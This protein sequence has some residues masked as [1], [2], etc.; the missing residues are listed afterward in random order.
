[1][2]NHI[3]IELKADADASYISAVLKSLGLWTRSLK[4]SQNQIKAIEVLPPSIQ[5][6]STLIERIEG[7]ASVL[8][9][10]SPHP[11]VDQIA[12]KPFQ[13][14]KTQL[15]HPQQAP[16]LIAG[17]CSVESEEVAYQVAEIVSKANGKW[18]RGGAFKP[19]TSPYAFQGAGEIALKWLRESAD[20]YG[21][22]VVT[23]ALSENSVEEVAKYAD[24]VQI[25]ARNM[26]NF[27]LLKA[28]GQVHKPVLL[29]RGLSATLEEWLLAGEYLLS[30][31]AEHVVFC[32]RGIRS[33]DPETRNVLDLGAVALLKAQG[34]PVVVDP[35]H[36]AGRR[37]IVM[38]LLKAALAVG[39]DA[40][41]VEVH[42]N[43]MNALSDGAQALSALQLNQIS[44]Y[45]YDFCEKQ[46]SLSIN[47]PDF[48]RKEEKNG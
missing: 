41:M 34:L 17:P 44:E 30:H 48:N 46:K 37:D 15:N 40:V 47:A 38:P 32:E 12:F 23:E 10:S 33:F 11:K 21:L 45:M 13:I 39:A 6:D 14:Q 29:K 8:G 20:Q 7:V 9:M 18:M 36:A 3:L 27:A 42:P 26:Q 19:R 24:V 5:I 25:G 2:K 16:F 22:S 35:S 31:G 4:N 43:A 28:V 1:M